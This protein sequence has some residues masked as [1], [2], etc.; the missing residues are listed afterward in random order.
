M[1]WREALSP[2]PRLVGRSAESGPRVEFGIWLPEAGI[3]GPAL[4]LIDFLICGA[5]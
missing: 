4:L 1:L 2:G 5:D 3:D